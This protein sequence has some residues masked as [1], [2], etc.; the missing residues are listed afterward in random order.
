[1][2]LRTKTDVQKL[3]GELISATEFKYD[4]R[5]TDATLTTAESMLI[6]ELDTAYACAAIW[7]GVGQILSYLRKNLPVIKAISIWIILPVH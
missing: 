1:M 4:R 3:Q 7:L 5:A 6:D 2:A